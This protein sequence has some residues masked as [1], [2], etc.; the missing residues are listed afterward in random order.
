MY[1]GTI[2]ELR[3][4][5]MPKREHKSIGLEQTLVE[6]E[7]VVERLEGGELGLEQALKEFERGVKLTR[8]CQTALKKAEQKVEMLL[9]KTEDAVPEPF[10]PTK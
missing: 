1:L 5:N 3:C 4:G 10:E 8:D 6:L 9:K 7:K 2:D